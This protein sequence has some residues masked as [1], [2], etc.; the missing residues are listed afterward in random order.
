[1]PTATT[2][3]FLKRKEANKNLCSGLSTVNID[4]PITTYFK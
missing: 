3:A 1:M 2:E 4:G